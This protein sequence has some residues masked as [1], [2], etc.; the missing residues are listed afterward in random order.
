MLAP[1]PSHHLESEIPIAGNPPYRFN[2]PESCS[3]PASGDLILLS[4]TGLVGKPHLYRGQIDLLVARE[5]VHNLGEAFLKSSMAPSAWA[6][7]TSFVRHLESDLPGFGNPQRVTLSE[8]W[9]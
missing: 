4:D 1:N 8:T 2:L 7:R 6:W 3:S 9:Y 5:L